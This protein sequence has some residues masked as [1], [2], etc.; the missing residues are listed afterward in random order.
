LPKAAY[1]AKPAMILRAAVMIAYMKIEVMTRIQY[2][3]RKKGRTINPRTAIK[4][5]I[6]NFF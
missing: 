3:S 2:P 4:P 1:P 5:I 6:Q